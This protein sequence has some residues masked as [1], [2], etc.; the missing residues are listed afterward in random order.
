MSVKPPLSLEWSKMWIN[1]AAVVPTLIAAGI[2]ASAEIA[3][4]N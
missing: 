4:A 1:R 3:V 2:E